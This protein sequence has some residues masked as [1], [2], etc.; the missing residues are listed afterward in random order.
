MGGLVLL[1]LFS[2]LSIGGT[3]AAVG[4]NSDVAP[5]FAPFVAD[6]VKISIEKH[7]ESATPIPQKRLSLLLFFHRK[8]PEIA[9][10]LARYLSSLRRV[11]KSYSAYY[12][13]LLLDPQNNV[14]LEEY[15]LKLLDNNRH[16]ELQ[17]VVEAM[18]TSISQN[19]RRDI[20]FL[21][22]HWEQLYPCFNKDALLWPRKVLVDNYQAKSLYYAG[23]CLIKRGQ[24]DEARE[25][26]RIASDSRSGWS[27]IYLD[28]A[29]FSTWRYE[30]KQ[31]AQK[32]IDLCKANQ[33]ARKHCSEYDGKP[34]PRVSVTDKTVIFVQS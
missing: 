23:L 28:Y 22:T 32:A 7:S 4:N 17:D 14:T 19:K 26:L 6:M 10:L 1:F 2:L 24:Q 9:L 8:D 34:L 29:A 27:N 31:A 11:E 21:T 13:A 16:N 30:D 3:I 33:Y 25:L 18:T 12:K 5:L 20:E 15:S